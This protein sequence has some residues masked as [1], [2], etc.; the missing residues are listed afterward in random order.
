MGVDGIVL[1]YSNADPVPDVEV[2]G[3]G[4]T[5]AMALTDIQGEFGF[6]G[7]PGG[8]FHIEPRKIGGDNGAISSLDAAYALQA[9]VKMRTLTAEQLVAC[10]VTG[11]GVVS[12]LDGARILQRVVGSSSTLP[13]AATCDSDWA[14]LP[15]ADVMP[16]QTV[17]DPLVTAASC[18]P[19]AVTFAPLGSDAQ[20]QDFRAVL[21][22]DC[23]GSWRPAS[24]SPALV[25]RSDEP[26]AHLGRPRRQGTA[27]GFV[28]PLFVDVA[29]PFHAFEATLIF[30]PA[31]VRSVQVRIAA[32]ASGAL[33]R[34][35]SPR[36]GRLTVALA[37]ANPIDPTK[38]PILEVFY[39]L[40]NSNRRCRVRIVD[41]SIDE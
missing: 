7:V 6:A 33:L 13:V 4:A 27:S 5:N 21:F 32:A 39:E 30:D 40:N 15:D 34:T 19:G 10:D 37:S 41:V 22:G 29:E 23:T 24:G 11:N 36:D 1:Y 31:R 2:H 8:D 3:T 16:H 38:G 35:N 25:R 14:F 9:A 28:A 20:G 17:F 26:L 18:Q 12:S